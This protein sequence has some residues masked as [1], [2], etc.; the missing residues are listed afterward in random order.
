MKLVWASI[1][2][3]HYILEKDFNMKKLFN[4]VQELK[5]CKLYK[6]G[7][8]GLKL[9]KVFKCGG[10]T[11]LH[12]LKR[13]NIIARLGIPRRFNQKQERKICKLYKS[14]HTG[15]EIGNKFNCAQGV[16]LNY[17]ERNKVKRRLAIKRPNKILL[18][19]KTTEDRINGEL[20]GDGC[21]SKKYGKW[22]NGNNSNAW[23]SWG[24]KYKDYAE[25]I[26]KVF[27]PFF[28]IK[29][30]YNIHDGAN[31]RHYRYDIWS[32]R[33]PTFTKL[34]KKW[35]PYGKKIIPQDLVLTPEVCL[36]WYLG[37]G[38]L[39]KNGS[40]IVL[41][42]D[43]FTECEVD[44]LIK[45]FKRD[46]KIIST[47]INIINRR[48]RIRISR[49]EARKFLDYIGSCFVNC[50]QYKWNWKNS[51]LAIKKILYLKKIK[52]LMTKNLNSYT[53]H[54]ITKIS[55]STVRKYRKLLEKE[56]LYGKERNSR[57]KKYCIKN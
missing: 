29:Y 32:E 52:Q 35:Y 14:G 26:I 2:D 6:S 20:L 7:N 33:N 54:K 27:K 22:K 56:E 50:Y 38:C 55:D 47:K 3:I 57:S 11:I 53:I 34:R 48:Y 1:V 51:K 42:T 45:L 36:H 21:L 12:V 31:G 16:I 43:D 41:C 13:N 9:A 4:K 15:L 19:S 24:L 25:Y 39:D 40:H 28:N 23:L 37:D 44:F 17:L 46:V 5:I 8:T 10:S 18:L 49:I 30:N